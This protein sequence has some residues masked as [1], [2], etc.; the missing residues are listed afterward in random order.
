MWVNCLVIYTYAPRPSI[1]IVSKYM[2]KNIWALAPTNESNVTS[3]LP[4]TK[5]PLNLVLYKD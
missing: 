3:V 1:N 4:K 5:T 2:L